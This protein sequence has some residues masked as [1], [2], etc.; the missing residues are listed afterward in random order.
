[1]T[2]CLGILLPSGLV[3][4]SDSRSNAGVDQVA[5]V[6][7]LA[8]ITQP[9]KRLIAILSAGNLATTQLVITTLRQSVGSGDINDDLYAATTMFDVAN[10]VGSKLREVIAHE[11]PF[12]QPYGDPSGSFLV[13]GQ[14]AGEPPRLFQIYSAGNFIEASDR[15]PF[16][17]IGE[18]KY[19]R[20]ILDRA[21]TL[22]SSLDEA[23]KLALLSFDATIRS[24]LSVGLPIDIL[25]YETDSFS[26]ANL[27]TLEDHNAYWRE[28]RIGYSEGLASL[29]AQLPPPP[30]WGRKS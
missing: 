4:A 20:P 28:L 8:L 10:I 25:R 29:V 23:A 24:N 27:A 6:R 14:I 16:L 9:G 7:K 17:Q 5:R 21:L 18:T 12:V 11:G 3:L 26:D 22:E 2:Y 15:S 19:G 1:M 30:S 13:G